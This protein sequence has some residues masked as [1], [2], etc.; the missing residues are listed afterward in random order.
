MSGD[1]EWWLINVTDC[2]KCEK[3]REKEAVDGF[4]M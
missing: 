2:C 1:D 4:S 3:K